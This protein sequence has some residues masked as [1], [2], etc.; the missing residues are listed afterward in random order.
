MIKMDYHRRLG[1]GSDVGNRRR[2]RPAVVLV[3]AI[4]LVLTFCGGAAPAGASTGRLPPEATS[5][6]RLAESPWGSAVAYNPYAPTGYVFNGF[7]LLEL[8]YLSY[9]SSKEAYQHYFYP[10]LAT[11]WKLTR[12]SITLHLQPRARW[13]NGAPLTSADVL[14]SLL[15]AG[16]DYNQAWADILAVHTPSRSS[17][18][19]DLKPQAVARNVLTE[20]VQIPIVPASQYGRLVPKGFE[21]DLLTYWRLYDVLHPTTASLAAAS[22]SPAGKTL[23]K[24]AAKIPA[25]KPS[26]L[27]GD[28]PYTLVRANSTTVLLKKW[29]GWWD[30]KVVRAP[31]VELDAM[32]PTVMFGALLGGHFELEDSSEFLDPD[33]TKLE[34]TPDRKYVFVPSPTWQI[35]L[36]FHVPDYPFGIRAVRE[37]FAYIL[38]RTKIAQLTTEGKLLQNPPADRLD[39]MPNIMN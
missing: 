6:F 18:V 30:A 39:G 33:V 20:V 3:V 24:V 7:V 13:S 1:A 32:D 11:G 10:E 38:N 28:G 25:F 8:A 35:G 2:G 14:T 12:S 29:S 19:I 5:A 17:V 23:A 27:I 22:D 4:A 21:H 36:L 16:G 34:A 9:R 15:V 26:K 31:W 37:A